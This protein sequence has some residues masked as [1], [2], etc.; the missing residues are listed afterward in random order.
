LRSDHQRAGKQVEVRL[1][2]ISLQGAKSPEK[3]LGKGVAPAGRSLHLLSKS[4][5]RCGEL[6]LANGTS[7]VSFGK[8]GRRVAGNADGTLDCIHPPARHGRQ[9]RLLPVR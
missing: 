9:P 7:R 3:P 6:A 5:S 8:V 2:H 1:S 4:Q